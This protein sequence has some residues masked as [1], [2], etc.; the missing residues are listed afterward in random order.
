LKQG[1][2]IAQGKWTGPPVAGVSAPLPLILPN[3]ATRFAATAKRL[4]ILAPGHPAEPWLRFVGQLAAGQHES[5]TCADSPAPLSPAVVEQSVAQRTPPLSASCGTL[6]PSWH[7]TLRG[8][9]DYLQAQAFPDEA[10][11]ALE[12]LRNGPIA[13]P[14]VLAQAFLGGQVAAS[15]IGQAFYVAAALQVHFTRRAAQL[16]VDTLRL[17]PE[18]GLCPCC[19]SAPVAGVVTASGRAPGV[20]YLHCSLCSAAWNHVRAVCIHCGAAGKLAQESIEGESG[21]VK[22]ETCGHCGTYSKLLD[23]RVDPSL[24]PVADDLASLGLDLL[25][26]EAGWTRHAPNPLVLVA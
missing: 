9:L 20:R 25:V 3:P 1:E 11:S 19:G 17:L 16:P 21:L 15:Q 12:Q 5:A 4:A 10:R 13:A 26:G 18:R 6:E 14:D 2:L 24:D 7:Q 22:A 23:E 8:I